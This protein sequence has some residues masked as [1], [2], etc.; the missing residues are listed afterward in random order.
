M[1]TARAQRHPEGAPTSRLGRFVVASLLAHAL[2]AAPL[3]DSGFGVTPEPAPPSLLRVRVL[4]RTAPVAPT[5]DRDA[6][7]AAST[8]PR[9]APPPEPT[10]D[11]MDRVA[12]APAP[13]PPPEARPV[14]PP[15][16]PVARE[17]VPDV[18]K[19]STNEL[20]SEVLHET[21]PPVVARPV[22]A[23]DSEAP[24]EPVNPATSNPPRAARS[25]AVASAALPASAAEP[26]PTRGWTEPDPVAAY[27]ER[28][29]ARVVEHRHY[30]TLARRRGIEGDVVVR[31]AIAHD[32][33]LRDVD[34]V[35]A[36]HRLL[37]RPTLEAVRA[38]EPFPPPPEGVGL[39]ELSVDYRIVD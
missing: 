17:P 12:P 31:L 5:P 23:L 30:P 2:L 13:P 27:V 11:A 8:P 9:P 10:R 25:T 1:Q 14:L 28:V 35:G 20:R 19:D 24:P 38:A 33:T 3:L 37:E 7:T 21:T 18:P 15:A 6:A 16:H 22:E 29:R 36:A 39:I 26:P 4:D 32:G 34:A